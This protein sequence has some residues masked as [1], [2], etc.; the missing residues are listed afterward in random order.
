MRKREDLHGWIYFF[1]V[2]STT[3]NNH[4]FIVVWTTWIHWH[5]DHCFYLLAFL[6]C[7][8]DCT[9]CWRRGLSTKKAWSDLIKWTSTGS[10]NVKASFDTEWR[11]VPIIY[12]PVAL[13]LLRNDLR[14]DHFSNSDDNG[15]L[16][17]ILGASTHFLWSKARYSAQNNISVWDSLLSILEESF[18]WLTLFVTPQRGCVTVQRTLVVGLCAWRW[19]G[20]NGTVRLKEFRKPPPLISFKVENKSLQI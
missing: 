11:M 19:H 3:A 13:D 16:A 10:L 7:A 20:G 2:F 9:R 15:W 14:A 8:G 4:V 17:H 6:I 5:H 1:S 18:W 12:W